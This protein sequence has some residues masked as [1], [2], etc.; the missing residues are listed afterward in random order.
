MFDVQDL[1]QAALLE[2][3]IRDIGNDTRLPEMWFVNAQSFFESHEL[4]SEYLK[5]E[6]PSGP[7]LSRTLRAA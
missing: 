4:L 6:S 5:V 2:E 1:T 3:H 7:R